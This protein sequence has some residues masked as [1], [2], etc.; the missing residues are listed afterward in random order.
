VSDNNTDV[1]LAATALVN[2]SNSAQVEPANR[3]VNV[4]DDNKKSPTDV[5]NAILKSLSNT[6]EKNSEALINS[7]YKALDKVVNSNY[8]ALDKVIK[9]TLKPDT[10]TKSTSTLDKKE[11]KVDRASTPK[12]TLSKALDVPAKSLPV[13]ETGKQF[14][15]SSS[16]N[17]TQY[18][19]RVFT[20]L[21]KVL[22]IGKFAE[23]PEAG[24]LQ[25]NLKES[26]IKEVTKGSI[27]LP[28]E[29]SKKESG[30]LMDMLKYLGF[31]AIL[32]DILSGNFESVAQ[33]VYQQIKVWAKSAIKGVRG[34]A[35]RVAKQFSKLK[36]KLGN[37]LTKITSSK[38]FQG[39]KDTLSTMGKAISERFSSIIE[40][41]KNTL[42]SIKTG[43]SK[44]GETVKNLFTSGGATAPPPVAG[45]TAASSAVGMK[46]PAAAPVSRLNSA[47][48]WARDTGNKA[49]NSGKQAVNT[50]V[51]KPVKAV[52][53]AV[54]DTGLSALRGAITKSGGILKFLKVL[55]K[56]IKSISS[57]LPIVGP[58]I[59]LF[60]AKGDIEKYKAERAENSITDQEL[61]KKSGDRLLEGI[62]GVLGGS[63]GAAL[64]VALGTL[65][66]PGA[67]VLGP[68]G[69]MLGG[70]LGDKVG[71]YAAT[72]ASSIIPE[73]AIGSVGKAIVTGKLLPEGDTGEMQDF[74][75]K[76]NQ[77][78][79]F[80]N[81]D[82]ILGM[83]DGGA[84]KQLLS[85]TSQNNDKQLFIANRQVSIL[86]QIRD[87]IMMLTNVGNNNNKTT[88]IN[89][90]NTNNQK[91]IPS[92]T[93]LRSEF[94]GA[95]NLKPIY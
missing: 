6:A 60:F 27:A 16:S 47:L 33:A 69:A 75:I 64:G 23:G 1:I 26:K 35:T 62:G 38:I 34:I 86:E 55:G 70:F 66:G 18:Y 56:G 29:T 79:K 48:N 11:S 19:T 14:P 21:G 9:S 41:V 67:V 2:A 36:G 12:E 17:E 65:T 22:G 8:K 88:N 39:I 3:T 52:G 95:H 40:S 80:S 54:V 63:A 73:S 61:Y 13:A 10:E 42:K 44:A 43:L 30:G 37:V 90:G 77:V 25:A 78:Y 82:E 94:N 58:L 32:A 5:I 51:V 57:K 4:I 68:L 74:I 15:T 59:E 28:K 24:R 85:S 7:N 89:K 31:G 72:I 71:R 45:A 87:G 81:K 20:I 84:V 92:S 91:S 49:W 50:Y 53:K 83:K 93:F 76:N 46:P